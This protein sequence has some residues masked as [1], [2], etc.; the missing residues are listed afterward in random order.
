VPVYAPDEGNHAASAALEYAVLT[1]GVRSIVVMGHGRCGGVAAAL[2]GAVT[3]TSTDFIGTWVS[4]LRDL[5]EALDPSARADGASS[6]LERRVVERSLANLRT[7]PW[8]QSRERAGTLTLHGCWFDVAL[9]E[10]HELTPSG[11]G[12]VG[13]E[14]GA[15]PGQP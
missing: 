4:G 15:S 3:R 6:N 2:D 8:I 9:G 5:T 12:R 1:L 7:F 11:W 14:A 13:P 10:L